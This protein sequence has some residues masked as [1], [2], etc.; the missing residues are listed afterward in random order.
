MRGRAGVVGGTEGLRFNITFRML[1]KC[2]RRE[3]NCRHAVRR[4]ITE[5]MLLRLESDSKPRY[6][7]S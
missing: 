2:K 4:S 6:S 7:Q 1:A 5:I 3:R